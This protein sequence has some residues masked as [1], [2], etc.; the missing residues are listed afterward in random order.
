MSADYTARAVARADNAT[1]EAR[2]ISRG[3]G[4]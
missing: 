2:K 1:E 4:M 3:D